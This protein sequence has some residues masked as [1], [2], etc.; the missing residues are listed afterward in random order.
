M[1]RGLVSTVYSDR[2]LDEGEALGQRHRVGL[3]TTTTG[4]LMGET[5]LMHTTRSTV[6]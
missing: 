2:S 3:G 1:G 4:G 5:E 6:I